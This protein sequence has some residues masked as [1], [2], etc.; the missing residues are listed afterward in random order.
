MENKDN[1]E[2]LLDNDKWVKSEIKNLL[3]IIGEQVPFE[4]GV[5]SLCRQTG[6]TKT[7]IMTYVR[8]YQKH[9]DMDK[10][11]FKSTLTLYVPSP[12]GKRL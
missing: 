7:E 11:E 3:D 1:L 4:R 9:Y 8:I 12:R 6:Y 2:I 5:D 10:K